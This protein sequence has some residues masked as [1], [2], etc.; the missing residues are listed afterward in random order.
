MVPGLTS[1]LPETDAGR[2]PLLFVHGLAHGPWCWRNWVAGAVARGYP[3]H[4][5]TLSGYGVREENRWRVTIGDYVTDVERVLATLPATTV[6]VGHSMGG[7]VVQRALSRLAVLAAALV[8][9]VPPRHGFA[10]FATILRHQPAGALGALAGRSLIFRPR[11]LFEA[12]DAPTAA[13]LAGRQERTAPLTQFQM[14]LPRRMPRPATAAKLL[15]LAASADR[16]IPRS[17]IRQ[18]A[19]FWDVQPH[20]YDGM[21]HDMMLDGGWERPLADLLDWLDTAV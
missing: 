12:L 15:L 2:P 20:W 5:L 7:L 18:T 21:G 13:D 6:L 1:V 17:D 9:P 10:T 3:A 16:V 14:T 11:M 4:T 8:A 19:R